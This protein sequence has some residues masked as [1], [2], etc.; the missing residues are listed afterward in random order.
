VSARCSRNQRGRTR[1]S[2][3]TKHDIAPSGLALQFQWGDGARAGKLRLF[4]LEAVLKFTDRL[5][6]APLLD[7]SLAPVPS[8]IGWP[9]YS[10][11]YTVFKCVQFM[12]RCYE[13]QESG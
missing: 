12:P 6:K 10:L 13:C 9:E 2:A 4:F 7:S 1:R 5:L 3:P 11:P 8:V